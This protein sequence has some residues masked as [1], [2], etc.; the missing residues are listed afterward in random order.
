MGDTGFMV[1]D[2]SVATKVDNELFVR[3]CVF[4]I[5]KVIRLFNYVTHMISYDLETN[6]NLKETRLSCFNV[7]TNCFISS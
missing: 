3:G 1:H 7:K 4:F 5:I 6:M 2:S